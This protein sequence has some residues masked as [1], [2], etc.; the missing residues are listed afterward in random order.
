MLW[1]R[2]LVSQPP[3]PIISQCEARNHRSRRNQPS[4]IGCE[5][6][7]ASVSHR[8]RATIWALIYLKLSEKNKVCVLHLRHFFLLL[9]LASHQFQKGYTIFP[10]FFK[11]RDY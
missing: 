1:L 8:K 4:H 10:L 3:Q 9:K 11:R 7:S 2:S 5:A 6:P